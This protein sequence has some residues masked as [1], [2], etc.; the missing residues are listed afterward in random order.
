M[1]LKNNKFCVLQKCKVYRHII[2]LLNSVM[3]MLWCARQIRHCVMAPPDVS[4]GSIESKR[5][6]RQNPFVC[7]HNKIAT[8]LPRS[9]LLLRGADKVLRYINITDTFVFWPIGIFTQRPGAA[10]YTGGI[11][12]D[13]HRWDGAFFYPVFKSGE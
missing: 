5:Q 6:I 9:L 12:D 2:Y 13:L 11:S 8:A 10:R 7:G 3:R 4:K 1:D